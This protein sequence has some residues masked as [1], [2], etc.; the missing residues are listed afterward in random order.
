VVATIRR[1]RILEELS[2]Y[3]YLSVQEI[4]ERFSCSVATARRDVQAL[5]TAGHL[6]RSHGGAL[7]AGQPRPS[8]REA[9]VAE[10]DPLL[11]AKQRIGRAAAALVANG[12][13]I[14]LSGGTTSY[15]VARCLRGR[16]IG[17]VTNAVD[18]ALELASEAGPRVVLV[19]GVLDFTHGHELLGP[20]AEQALA[21][22]NMD[23]LF[24]SVNGIT[25]SAG[26]T[27]IGELNAQVMRVMAERAQ[28]VVVVAD[29]TKIGRTA[30]SRLMPLERV[31]TFIT[32]AVEASQEL[33][34]IRAAGVRVVE[35]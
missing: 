33:A 22:I 5:A 15:E 27:I 4:A 7:A 21:Q 13:T 8:A 18:L 3:H 35:A 10:P 26:V 24:V 19:G 28:R 9:G 25:A 14:G 34:A 6:Q 32:D 20:L 17:V 12:E 30:V 11:A 31:D 16:P 29:R 23:V 2:R 1:T